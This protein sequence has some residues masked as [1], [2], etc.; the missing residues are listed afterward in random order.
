M[1]PDPPPWAEYQE[2]G[3][4]WHRATDGRRLRIYLSCCLHL[5]D[6]FRDILNEIKGARELGYS[7]PR[8]V[9]YVHCSQL[10]KGQ[11]TMASLE[12]ILR[13]DPVFRAWT[14][15]ASFGQL[16]DSYV[17]MLDEQQL[18]LL[19]CFAVDNKRGMLPSHC[20]RDVTMLIGL[21]LDLAARLRTAQERCLR[22]TTPIA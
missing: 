14:D 4:E 21:D 18:T 22:Q 2:V 5:I 7:R 3:D 16:G 13:N 10:H 17:T 11:M 12:E 9:L 15:M 8:D 19:R 6:N 1:R 20:R